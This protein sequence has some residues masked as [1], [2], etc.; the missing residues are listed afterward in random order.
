[1]PEWSE[2]LDPADKAIIYTGPW[3]VGGQSWKPVA[4]ADPRPF[5]PVG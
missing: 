1:M 2:E 5:V 3:G 4:A